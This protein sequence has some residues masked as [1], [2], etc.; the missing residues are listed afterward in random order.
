MAKKDEWQCPKC[1]SM[2]IDNKMFDFMNFCRDCG[3]EWEV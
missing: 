1:G 2:N 3:Y